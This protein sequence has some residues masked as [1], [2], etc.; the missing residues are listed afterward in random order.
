MDFLNSTGVDGVSVRGDLVCSETESI[1]NEIAS[2][3]P[4]LL[5]GN[6]T[7]G[8]FVDGSVQC[9]DCGKLH[10][11]IVYLSIYL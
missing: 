10:E 8:F 1:R 9:G 6:E 11:M 7:S 2:V 3:S 5:I 4:S